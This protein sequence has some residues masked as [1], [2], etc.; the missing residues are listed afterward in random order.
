MSLL[1]P[2]MIT[3]PIVPVLCFASFQEAHSVHIAVG[4][5]VPD[6][7]Q[8]LRRMRSFT[9]VFGGRAVKV[10]CG[11]RLLPNQ[12]LLVGG[13]P[14]SERVREAPWVLLACPG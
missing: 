7:D 6:Q 9:S 12:G 3:Q 11:P 8:E 4:W 13:L 1:F 10:S 2:A 5:S 14:G